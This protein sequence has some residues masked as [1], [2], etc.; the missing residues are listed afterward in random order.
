MLW[1][2]PS[3]KLTVRCFGGIFTSS[4]HTISPL[5]C[6]SAF[7]FFA[8]VRGTDLSAKSVSHFRF[9]PSISRPQVAKLPKND[10]PTLMPK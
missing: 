8:R 10:W 4:N 9:A 5:H 1:Q 3:L 2:W 7:S 6:P